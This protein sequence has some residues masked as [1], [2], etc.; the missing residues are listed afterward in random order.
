[1]NR[2]RRFFAF[3]K[4]YQMKRFVFFFNFLNIFTKFFLGLKGYNWGD[5]S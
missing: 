4:A 3:M 5:C 2:Q 1:M